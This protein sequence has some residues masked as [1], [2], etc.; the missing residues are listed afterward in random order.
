MDLLKLPARW[1]AGPAAAALGVEGRTRKERADNLRAD[2]NAAAD[3]E[4]DLGQ[5]HLA[6]FVVWWL[7]AAVTLPVVVAVQVLLNL[8]DRNVGAFSAITWGVLQFMFW[9]GCV[10]AAKALVAYYLLEG[11]WNRESRTWRAVMLA[12]A[13]DLAIALIATLALQAVLN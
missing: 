5:R 13:P 11:R 1:L 7:L 12:Q 9:M 4:I 2:M 8:V 3:D 10:H 6:R